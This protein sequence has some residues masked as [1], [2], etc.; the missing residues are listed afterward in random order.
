MLSG[1]NGER[2][3]KTGR[4]KVATERRRFSRS[5]VQS[6]LHTYIER[7]RSRSM[8]GD[9][10][11]CRTRI[12]TF[13]NCCAVITGGVDFAGQT[14]SDNRANNTNSRTD[15]ACRHTVRPAGRFS[16]VKSRAVSY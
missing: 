7:H 8:R 3:A 13:V 5:R 11:V 15:R 14:V 16:S 12:I 10:T 1:K 2:A 4:F 6:I 9:D